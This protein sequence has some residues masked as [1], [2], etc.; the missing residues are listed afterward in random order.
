MAGDAADVDAEEYLRVRDRELVDG[1]GSIHEVVRV[2]VFRIVFGLDE[3]ARE[4]QSAG[5][6]MTA[7]AALAEQIASHFR[8]WPVKP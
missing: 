3:V 2:L 6:G 1:V 7:L 4:V 5:R 8:V